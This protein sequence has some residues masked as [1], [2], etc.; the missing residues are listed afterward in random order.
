MNST[1]TRSQE[2]IFLDMFREL[3][4]WNQDISESPER[5]DPILRILL[6]LYASQLSR[7]DR[8][9]DQVWDI[10]SRSLIR[11]VC[12][13]TR[14]WPVPAYTVMKCEL[15]DPLVEVDSTTRLFYKEQREA[16]RTYFF[17][18]LRT[19]RLVAA[20]VTQLLAD[21]GGAARPLGLAYRPERAP[22][23]KA[24]AEAGPERMYVAIEFHGRTADLAGAT[25]FL[26]GDP[27]VL[28]ML[29]WSHW[30]ASN[31]DGT[32][33]DAGEFCPGLHD[34]LDTMFADD[35][36]NPRLWG[37]LRSSADM[38]RPLEDSFV[39][40]SEDFCASWK[41]VPA[42]SLLNDRLEP[43]P[44]EDAARLWIELTLPKRGNR[45]RLADGLGIDFGSFIAANRNELT[46]F[47]HTAGH[48][49]L[50]VELPEPLE[51]VLEITEVVD[52]NG[53]AYLPRYEMSENDIEHTYT[54]QDSNNH[55][56]LWFDFSSKVKLPP[57]S[58]TVR[59]AVT[60][61]VDGNGIDPNRVSELYENHPG[62]VSAT[63]ISP[64][65]GAAPS[66]TEEQIVTEVSTRLRSRNRALTYQDVADWTM[67]FDPRIRHVACEN[68]IQRTGHGVR[69][70]IV[71]RVDV[72][73]ADFLSREEIELLRRRLNGFLKSRSQ[74]NTHYQVEMVRL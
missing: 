5:M 28:K 59:Y 9:I 61:G 54:L 49:V 26:R 73:D 55:L 71:V 8:R 2:Q 74:V 58:I 37:S 41:A 47:R 15:R 42:G 22:A 3:R 46:L 31:A 35:E 67:T 1:T 72:A 70:C 6:Q 23:P 38:F 53:N 13:E 18:P 63:N 39:T 69:R 45:A 20:K 60:D 44:S 29:R 27:A 40:L 50:D 25:I 16:G 19:E 12:P 65:R 4:A 10:A 33:N 51:Q 68:G 43:P 11:S 21:H 57:D 17:T 30:R 48:R 36:G 56:T 24:A 64:S 34:S 32:F 14:R 7:I 62:I 66:K 52:D